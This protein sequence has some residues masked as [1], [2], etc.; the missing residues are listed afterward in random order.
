MYGS[1][2]LKTA[3]E[4]DGS[5]INY[6]F[7]F[8]FMPTKAFM[9]VKFE[10]RFAL[11]FSKDIFG[12]KT[13]SYLFL[14]KDNKGSTLHAQIYNDVDESLLQLNET[15]ITDSFTKG[16]GQFKFLWKEGAAQFSKSGDYPAA[17][18]FRLDKTKCSFDEE[19][20]RFRVYMTKK[21][22]GTAEIGIGE[23]GYL[24]VLLEA[25][26]S[27]FKAPLKITWALEGSETCPKPDPE[28][29][30]KKREEEAAKKD[31]DS[32]SGDDPKP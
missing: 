20:G 3:W 10:T 9:D 11:A 22:P 23:W 7:Y 12:S 25:G 15:G 21:E 4:K 27:D 14:R 18:Y 16:A 32:K 29:E 17:N 28:A 1:V 30:K 31:A 8:D 24:G 19:S 26:D 6:G 13:E 5:E 2:S